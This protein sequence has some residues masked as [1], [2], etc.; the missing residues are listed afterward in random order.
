MGDMSNFEDRCDEREFE[1]LRDYVFELNV[2]RAGKVSHGE[3]DDQKPDEYKCH[4]CLSLPAVL[5]HHPHT[6]HCK[7]SKSGLNGCGGIPQPVDSRDVG[8]RRYSG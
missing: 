4:A 8:R 3:E 7:E 5:L 6:K 1:R 2:V